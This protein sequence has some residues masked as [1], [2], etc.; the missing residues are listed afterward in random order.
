MPAQTEKVHSAE[1]Q[2]VPLRS[3]GKNRILQRRRSWEADG[4]KR[5][6]GRAETTR[7]TAKISHKTLK[8]GFPTIFSCRRVIVRVF[9]LQLIAWKA[10]NAAPSPIIRFP[11]DDSP[12]TDKEVALVSLWCSFARKIPYPKQCKYFFP[13]PSLCLCSSFSTIWISFTGA[14]KTDATSWCWKTPWRKCKSSSRCKKPE[15]SMPRLWISWKSPA[16][17]SQMWPTI[18]SST[19]NPC[20]RRTTSPTGQ[21]NSDNTIQTCFCKKGNFENMIIMEIKHFK[22]G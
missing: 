18:T 1:V 5:L 13:L 17:A 16:A 15:K 19:G 21:R 8:M 7:I 10:T 11:G 6:Q 3:E 20:G 2:D 9:L 12:R 14:R 4:V 22:Q